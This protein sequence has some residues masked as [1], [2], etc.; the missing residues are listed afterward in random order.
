M[1]TEIA[2]FMRKL[3]GRWDGHLEALFIRR[4]VDAAMAE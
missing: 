4:D 2:T 1:T 3:E